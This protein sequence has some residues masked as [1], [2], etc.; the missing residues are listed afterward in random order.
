MGIH[1]FGDPAT[2][3][4]FSTETLAMDAT[5][6]HTYAAEWTPTYVAFYVDDGL[7]KVSW[8]SPNYP[9]QF[10]VNIYEFADGEV[11]EPAEAYPKE[12]VVDFFRGY[13]RR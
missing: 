7:L 10:M 12:F 2:T 5:A 3:D 13:R 6:F 1:P 11:L 8:K 4:D 9:M